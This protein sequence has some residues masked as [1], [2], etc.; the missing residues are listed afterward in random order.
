MYW[1]SCDPGSECLESY[2]SEQSITS[3]V[4]VTCI[5]AFLPTVNQPTVINFSA[6]IHRSEA[7][8]WQKCDIY[9]FEYSPELNLIE[10][11]RRFMKYE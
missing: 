1:N 5:D 8:E 7:E 10:T 9:L 4:V 6:F 2:V 3:N 11:L